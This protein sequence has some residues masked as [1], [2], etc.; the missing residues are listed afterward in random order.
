M[1]KVKLER[2]PFCGWAAEMESWHGGGPK[3]VLV[4]CV[5]ETCAVQPE[6]S[7]ETP[8]E[9]ARRWNTRNLSL[10]GSIEQPSSVATQ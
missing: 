2:C 3:K 8:K 1:G 9:A 4:G 7:G 6:V 5:N 10:K